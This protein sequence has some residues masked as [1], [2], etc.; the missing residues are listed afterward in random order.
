[1]K[2]I[3]I[4][5]SALLAGCAASGQIQ[6]REGNTY[7]PYH[8]LYIDAPESQ[9]WVESRFELVAVNDVDAGK[10][11]LYTDYQ[12]RPDQE[13]VM[14][15]AGKDDT[16]EWPPETGEKFIKVDTPIGPAYESWGGVEA[17]MLGIQQIGVSHGVP[18]P[19]CGYARLLQHR[20]DAGHALF[21]AYTEG[22]LCAVAFAPR[23]DIGDFGEVQVRDRGRVI[24]QI[25]PR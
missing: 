22:A 20:N 6:N 23:G 3:A 10:V 11:W 21:I 18:V 14:V 15:F 24:V 25:K 7:S 2:C 8:K 19:S 12:G 17:S 4:A 13:F 5:L 1:M 16:P 9:V